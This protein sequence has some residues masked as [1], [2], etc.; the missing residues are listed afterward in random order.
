MDSFL[1]KKQVAFQCA[2][3]RTESET[4]EDRGKKISVTLGCVRGGNTVVGKLQVEAVWH[5]S[6]AD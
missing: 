3:T 2:V 6:T 1:F 5:P 4:L